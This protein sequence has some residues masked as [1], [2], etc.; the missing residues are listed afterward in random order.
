MILLLHCAREMT[1]HFSRAVRERHRALSI[2]NGNDGWTVAI[3]PPPRLLRALGTGASCCA[4]AIQQM[5][6]DAQRS[7]EVIC[8]AAHMFARITSQR[9]E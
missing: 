3:T 9:L 5:W 6:E 7:S 4:L 1:L 2:V 8:G